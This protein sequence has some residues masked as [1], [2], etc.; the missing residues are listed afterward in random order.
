MNAWEANLDVQYVTHVYSCV[1]YLASYITKPEKTLGDV[2]K[3][4][5]T[6]SQ[7]LGTKSSMRKVAHIFL[8]HREV[9]AQEAVYRLLSL[10][11][12][13]G[14]RQVI[15]LDTDLKE[16]RTRLFKSLNVIQ[17]LD[18]YDPVVYVTGM[19]DRYAARPDKLEN[20]CFMEFVSMYKIA[21]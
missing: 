11:L 2:P 3:A 6:S 5:S 8:T 17:N 16:N 7:H 10:P 20:M 1:I 4:V 19:N 21:T 12:T 14:S 9:S 18:D 13:Q 15:F